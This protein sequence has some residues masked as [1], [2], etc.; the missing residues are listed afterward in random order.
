MKH[1]ETTEQIIK[2][3]YKVYNTFGYGFLERVYL[4][5]LYIELVDAGFRVDK[6]KKFSF[7]I[8][9][10]SLGIIVQI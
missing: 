6:N 8:M 5:A 2:A 3:F 9:D 4:N 10:K 1:E 7:T